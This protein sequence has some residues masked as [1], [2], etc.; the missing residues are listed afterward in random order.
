[1]FA[2]S[3]GKSFQKEFAYLLNLQSIAISVETR[4]WGLREEDLLNLGIFKN[5]DKNNDKEIIKQY[6]LIMQFFFFCSSD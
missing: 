5:S 1:M 3:D 2:R 4:L 6:N